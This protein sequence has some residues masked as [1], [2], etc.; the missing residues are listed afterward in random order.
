[1]PS[2]LRR[3]FARIGS[4]YARL[5]LGVVLGLLV[6]RLLLQAVGDDG[7]AL[8]ALLGQ[9]IGFASL[10]KDVVRDC[11]IRE[12]SGAYHDKDPSRFRPIFSSSVL[13]C[14][15]IAVVS[16]NVYAL[17]YWLV[18]YFE[19]PDHLEDA[20]RYFILAKA[21]ESFLLTLTAPHF[22][23]YMVSERMISYNAWLLIERVCVTAAAACLLLMGGLTNAQG[24]IWYA[25]ISTSLWS[26]AMFVSVVWITRLDRRLIPSWKLVNWHDTRQILKIGA[27]QSA[28]VV[29]SN[30]HLRLNAI[31]MNAA[32][33]LAGSR[34]F[35]L[36]VQLSSYVR[37][38]AGGSSRGIEAVT[39]RIQ[40]GGDDELVRSFVQDSTR[41]AAMFALPAGVIIA[42]LSE[43][44]IWL[45]VGGRLESPDLEIPQV[46]LLVRVLTVGVV[47]WGLGDCWVRLLYGLGLVRKYAP[48]LIFNGILNPMLA[49]ASIYVLPESIRIAGPCLAFSGTFLLFY[50]FG[51]SVIGARL[52][53]IRLRDMHRP[54]IT[55][56]IASLIA[57]PTLFVPRLIW[58]DWGPTGLASAIIMYGSTYS[59]L[60]YW[61][62][63]KTSERQRIN[64][65]I[66]RLAK[67]RLRSGR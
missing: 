46:T 22:N 1:M 34:L 62:V 54:L 15:G 42:V 26:S 5:I 55:P 13:L 17:L 57:G 11:M 32:F 51:V 6:V 9:T 25:I 56:L 3:G 14:T 37:V 12:L 48:L 8:V 64:N 44:I 16:M 38:I 36:A 33:G 18:P 27:W 35:G 19:I 59:V 2:E 20:A 58:T 45:W 4:N 21:A 39:S 28:V 61:T 40:A 43:P 41:V 66:W 63:I 24:V 53:N 67:S 52:L 23:M 7:F 50:F 47:C 65:A 60:C 31:I 30:M 29:S 10:F 49:I